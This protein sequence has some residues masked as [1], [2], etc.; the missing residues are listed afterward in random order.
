MQYFE[1]IGTKVLGIGCDVIHLPAFPVCILFT[2]KKLYQ[3]LVILSNERP[4]EDYWIV[5]FFEH[6]RLVK[7]HQMTSECSFEGQ[8]RVNGA[9][10]PRTRTARITQWNSVQCSLDF[11]RKTA[12]QNCLGVPAFPPP[13]PP[14]IR[15]DRDLTDHK[16]IPHPV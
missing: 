3:R 9:C 7:K 4:K 12:G 5:L 14:P 15:I 8:Y 1:K 13:P 2:L 6:W 16:D 11:S 10:I